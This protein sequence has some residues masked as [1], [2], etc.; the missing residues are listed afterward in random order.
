MRVLL[1]GVDL[2]LPVIEFNG[3]FISELDSGRR[4]A[5]NVLSSAAACTVEAILETGA[6]PVVSGWDGSH[7]KVHFGRRMNEGTTWY[8]EEKRAYGDPRLTGCDD[9][10][11]AASDADVASV[12]GFIADAEAAS[13]VKRLRSAVGEEATVHSASNYYCPGW[14]EVQVRRRL[15]EKGA[16]VPALLRAVT[17][18]APMS[19]PVAITSTTLAFSSRGPLDRS[20]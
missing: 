13:A 5:S 8:V 19:S 14:T 11:S 1:G 12:V 20:G 6:D 17:P 10:I 4:L 15:A 9:L 2:R 18:A 16:A 7:D 3:A